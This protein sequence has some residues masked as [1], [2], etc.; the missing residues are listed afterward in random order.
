VVS[1]RFQ[2]VVAN[3]VINGGNAASLQLNDTTINAQM[4]YTLD[5]STP[6]DDGSNT[7]SVG[8]I[9]PGTTISLNIQSNVTL[10]VRGFQTGF[11]PSGISVENLS[12]TNFVANQLTFGFPTGEEASSAFIAAAGQ[13]FVAPVTLTLLPGAKMYTLQFNAT[14]TNLGAAPSPGNS[15]DFTSMLVQPTQTPGFYVPIDPLMFAN[16]GFTNGV[17]TND[18]LN[19]IGVGWLERFGKTNLY[20]TESQDVITYSLA[21][22][23]LFLSSGGKVIVG[24]YSFVVPPSAQNGQQYRIQLGRPSASADGVGVIP[25]LIVA[26]TNGSLASGSINSIKNVTVGSAK[27]L[28][29][30]V[31]QFRWFNAGDFGDGNLDASDVEEVF[32]TAVYGLNSPPPSDMLD[33][34]DSS[35]AGI[36][37]N[38]AIYTAVF[39]GS[40]PAAN[41]IIDSMMFGDGQLDISDVYVTYR[42]SLDPSLAWYVRFWSNGILNVAATSNAPQKTVVKAPAK[43]GVSVPHTLTVGADQVIASSS[44][45]VVPLRVLAGDPN[46]LALHALMFDVSLEALDGS[47]AVTTPVTFTPSANLGSPL[48][49]MSKG[50]SDYAGVWL[51]TNV[52]ISG[53]GIIGTLTFM[54]PDGV[55]SASAYRVLISG[56]S[57]SP[58]GLGVFKTT[59]Q[60]GLVTLSDR[61]ASSW[62]DGISDAWRLLNFG[63]ISDPSSA[64]SADPDGDGASNWQEYLA[65]TDPLNAASV[66]KLNAGA[67]AGSSVFNLQWPTVVGKHYTLQS[68]PSGTPGTWTTLLSNVA[69]SGNPMNWSDTSGAQ[70][71]FFRATV[72]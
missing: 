22:D 63:T 57:G 62:N 16:P 13:R 49:T 6:T 45:V 42:R 38:S 69:G 15:F 32:Q 28:V 41:S 10:N 64:A 60:N 56:F 4:F 25:A 70:A 36:N 7:N 40:D 23:D 5:G 14:V 29:G 52:G 33:A 67:T 53:S 59:V 54:L 71:K 31:N 1:A 24:G 47:P 66:F 20:N 72:Q 51:N 30:D 12:V 2:F 65:G 3:P 17:F 48:A 61:S 35:D 18:S 26:P 9:A 43:T 39:N 37:P 46:N 19:L 58:N 34:M 68:S 50:P 8:P 55:S 21:K 11:A 44:S 27:Y